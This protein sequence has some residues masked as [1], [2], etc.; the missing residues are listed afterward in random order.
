MS[1]TNISKPSTSLS[2]A[3][4]INIGLVWSADTFQ[5]QNESRT[6][7]ETVSV[8]DNVTK[9]SSSISNQSKP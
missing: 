5:W 6:W 4:K 7:G 2:N 8:I 1:I 9:I 3:T